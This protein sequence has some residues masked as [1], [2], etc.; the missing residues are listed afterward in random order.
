MGTVH[1]RERG[2]RSQRVDA[3]VER[4]EQGG[5]VNKAAG[6][7]PRTTSPRARFLPAITRRIGNTTIA[8]GWN[9]SARPNSQAAP[10][11]LRRMR[12]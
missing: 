4:G 9:A 12:K 11:N 7:T 3:V 1:V 5:A 6:T 10:T 2:L 8:S